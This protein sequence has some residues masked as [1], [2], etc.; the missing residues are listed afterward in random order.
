MNEARDRDQSSEIQQR[1]D[2]LHQLEASRGQPTYH[3]TRKPAAQE[4]KLSERS[5]R[6]LQHIYRT[7]K[8]SELQ[9]PERTDAGHRKTEPPNKDIA[10]IRVAA[11]YIASCPQR[12]KHN[13]KNRNAITSAGAATP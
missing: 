12:S 2:I 4:L 8:S 6:R 13:S 10:T 5:L 1:I 11:P 3:Q 9:R 7:Q